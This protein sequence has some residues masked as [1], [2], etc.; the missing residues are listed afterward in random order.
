MDLLKGLTSDRAPV[1]L[2]VLDAG[3]GGA[4]LIAADGPAGLSHPDPFAGANSVDLIAGCNDTVPECRGGGLDRGAL[5]IRVRVYADKVGC[6]DD[7]FV[8]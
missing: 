2:S 5:E 7:G 8:G 6:G 1:V 4:V 3:N